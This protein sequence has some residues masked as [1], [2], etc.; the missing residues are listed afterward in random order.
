MA[1]N[2]IRYGPNGPGHQAPGRS[3]SILTKTASRG[4]CSIKFRSTCTSKYS[5]LLNEGWA[6]EEGGNGMAI[7]GKTVLSITRITFF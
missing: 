6:Y 2:Q 3:A 4:R 7:P 5:A 1:G